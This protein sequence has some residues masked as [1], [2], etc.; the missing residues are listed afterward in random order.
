MTRRELLA[1]MDA[2]EFAEW[3]AY[4]TIEADRNFQ[5]QLAKEAE[6]GLLRNK[7]KRVRER[8]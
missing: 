8:K 7:S 2:R 3:R 6:Q 4:Y 5:E 1:G